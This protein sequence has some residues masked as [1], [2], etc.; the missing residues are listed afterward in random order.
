MDFKGYSKTDF[1]NRAK[2][3]FCYHISLWKETYQKEKKKKKRSKHILE[4]SFGV[5][6]LLQCEMNT[7]I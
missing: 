7:D 6:T 4:L 3:P 1:Y 2:S 5:D